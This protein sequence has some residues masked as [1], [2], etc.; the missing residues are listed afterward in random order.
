[1]VAVGLLLAGLI[2]FFNAAEWE[3]RDGSPNHRI[4]WSSLSGLVSALVLFVAGWGVLAWLI[5]QAGL[6]VGIA[7]VRAAL[8]ACERG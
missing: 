1:M 7:V 5:A 8:E 4:L 3:A 6:F 2:I